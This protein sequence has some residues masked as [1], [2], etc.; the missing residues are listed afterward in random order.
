MSRKEAAAQFLRLAAVGRTDEAFRDSIAPDFVHHNPHFP[1]TADAL[2]AGM[3]AN[4]QQFP[5]KRIEILRTIGEGDLVAVHS[6]LHLTPD[7]RGYALVHIFRFSG[8]RVAELWP[9]TMRVPAAIAASLDA[10]AER[11]RID[12]EATCRAAAAPGGDPRVDREALCLDN[13]L[14]ELGATLDVLADPSVAPMAPHAVAA[15]PAVARCHGAKPAPLSQDSRTVRAER[16]R[17][18]LAMLAAID[19]RGGATLDVLSP[20][21]ERLLGKAPAATPEDT[22]EALESAARGLAAWRGKGAFERADALHAIADEMARRKDEAA[23]MISTETGKPLA[24]SERE[25]I[26]AIDQFR[27]S[28]HLEIVSVFRR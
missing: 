13:Q 6:R 24:Q 3:A 4:A 22:G 1:H 20:V 28:P 15:L 27:W 8:D 5:Q 10:W 19:A 21:T 17:R 12:R 16:T 25:W 7:D 14:V 26:L 18:R 9:S 2:A 23:R 11:W